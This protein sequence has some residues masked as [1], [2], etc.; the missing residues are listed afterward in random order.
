MGK[1]YKVM[2]NN[3]LIEELIKEDG[4]KFKVSNIDEAY[5]FCKKIAT[6]HYE[7]F[8][9]ASFL[10]PKNKRKFIY[11]IYAF[12]RVADDIADNVLIENRIDKLNLLEKKLL[13]KN[14]QNPLF[15][16]LQDSINQ[17][18][19]DINLL[20]KLLKAF[21]YDSEFKVF[22][23]FDD[24]MLYCDNSANPVGRLILQLFNEENVE[25]YKYSDKICTALQLV[26]F[27][28][29]LSTDL[30]NNRNYI[31][32]SLL[33]KYKLNFDNFCEIENNEDLSKILNELFEKT[34]KLFEDG[35]NIIKFVK[36]KRLQYELKFIILGGLNILNLCKRNKLRLLYERPNQNKATY[37]KFI[38]QAIVWK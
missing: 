8:P 29:D 31:P 34:E 19:L 10:L 22:S 23:N 3:D 7:N 12:A 36:S 5:S 26:N 1:S 13:N 11:P 16:A 25:A 32:K 38:K 18:K 4:G 6:N 35:K 9:V 27:W 20:I 17:N 15:F 33:E 28:Q 2:L 24:L 14:I 21:K 37:L 30:K